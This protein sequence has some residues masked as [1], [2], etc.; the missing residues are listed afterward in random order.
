[1]N[2]CPVFGSARIVRDLPYSASAR[3]PHDR[4]RWCSLAFLKQPS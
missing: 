2:K 1:M 3:Y 4:L